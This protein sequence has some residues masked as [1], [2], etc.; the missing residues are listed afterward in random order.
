VS[1]AEARRARYTYEPA[2]REAYDP[3]QPILTVI[4]DAYYRLDLVEQSVQSVLDQEY[5]N[6]ELILIDNAAQ[7]EVA[8]Y[9][10][11]VHTTRPNV[12]LI[13]FA[14]NQ[15]SW[16]DI[17][18][19]VATCWNAALLHAS[20]EYVA[21]LSYDDMLS[22]NYAALMVRL[23]VENPKCVTAAPLPASIAA[24]GSRNGAFNEAM[25]QSNRRGRFTPGIALAF[26]L[27]A[28]SPNRLFAAPGE[29]LVIRRKELLEYGGFDRL[30]DLTQILKYA[31]LGDSGFDPNARV[32]WRHHA[33]QVN[34]QAKDRGFVWY[35]SGKDLWERSG[36]VELWRERFAP[37][38]VAAL[39]TFR[40]RSLDAAPI[41]V[42][43]DD[44]RSGKLRTAAI[45]AANIVR[46]CPHLA[47]RALRAAAA[48]LVMLLPRGLYSAMR[49]AAVSVLPAETVA[50]WRA[51]R[52]AKA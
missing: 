34:K 12:P 1:I 25:V 11:D 5:P 39:T 8:R 29:L 24:D 9:L 31:I 36:V 52:G 41:A 3:G 40:D 43:R 44:I 6:V 18:M 17:A 23:F 33:E 35:A 37:D 28:G 48:E 4:L 7:P 42:L 51:R 19:P 13:R 46:E 14:E 27:I 21:H 45:A 47:P 22:P 30:C 38:V 2:T 26:D 16:D 10:R 32:Y 15:F 50:A 49:R 20:G